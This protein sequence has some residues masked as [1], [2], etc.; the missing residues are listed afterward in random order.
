MCEFL[1][2]LVFIA[3]NG[4]ENV[5]YCAY[6]SRLVAFCDIVM[7]GFTHI[8]LSCNLVVSLESHVA[9]PFVCS[10]DLLRSYSKQTALVSTRHVTT[11]NQE[12]LVF[13]YYHPCSC[14]RKSIARDK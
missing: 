10:N 13:I 11:T 2:K 14:R 8:S 12:Y 3:V 7:L 4:D 5:G 9:E 6:L 1:R